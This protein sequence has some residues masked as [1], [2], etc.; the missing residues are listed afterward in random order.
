MDWKLG[1]VMSRK[2]MYFS[3]ALGLAIPAAPAAQLVPAPQAGAKN[4]DY[5][6]V[7]VITERQSEACEFVRQ[8][9]CETSRS[10]DKCIDSHRDHAA[11]SGANA[12]MLMMTNTATGAFSVF[13]KNTTMLAN[14]YRCPV[15]D[16]PAEGQVSG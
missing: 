11:K 9:T 12:I 6:Q 5:R 15:K 3:L 13:G 10:A 8:R 2:A 7:V 1:G 4:L 16:E 14:Y